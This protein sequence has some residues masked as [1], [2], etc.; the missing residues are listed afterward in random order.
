MTSLDLATL[1]QRAVVVNQLPPDL[2]VGM[3]MRSLNIVFHSN[4]RIGQAV[5][6][7]VERWVLRMT[8]HAVEF[9]APWPRKPVGPAM[10]RARAAFGVA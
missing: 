3:D 1:R 10:R 8:D 4:E 7:E 5:R 9:V 2:T 6:S